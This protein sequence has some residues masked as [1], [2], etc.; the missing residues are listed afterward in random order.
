MLKRIVTVLFVFLLILTPVAAFADSEEDASYKVEKKDGGTYITVWG[1]ETYKLYSDLS[2]KNIKV[3]SDFVQGEII[4]DE[5]LDEIDTSVAGR[6]A[7]G[8]KAE[9]EG[10]YAVVYSSKDNIE[11]SCTVREGVDKNVEGIF[12]NDVQIYEGKRIT[13]NFFKMAENESEYVTVTEYGSGEYEIGFV[14]LGDKITDVKAGG[15][16]I[17]PYAAEAY[18][19]DEMNERAKG[20]D[21]YPDTLL[22]FSLGKTVRTCIFSH[23]DFDAQY[24]K[25]L[26]AQTEILGEKF[27]FDVTLIKIESLVKDIS[28]PPDFVP[29]FT[30]TFDG[31]I[32]NQKFPQYIAVEFTDGTKKNIG[33]ND[34]ITLPNGKNYQVRAEY[35]CNYG[36]GEHQ[37][38]FPFVY[39]FDGLIYKEVSVKPDCL[40]VSNTLSEISDKSKSEVEFG[41]RI[42]SAGVEDYTKADGLKF[43]FSPV[44]NIIDGCRF[45][46]N[47]SSPFNGILL[48]LIAFSPVIL[49]ILIVLA[50]I[51]IIKAK[52]HK[53]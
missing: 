34:W 18:D 48:F 10:Y 28:L 5:F 27:D 45:Y 43:V 20:V 22:T 7:F 3:K 23:T 42:L 8:I 1:I 21:L 29:S 46:F 52:K 51:F 12:K 53:K 15:E 32:L 33:F 13:G 50:V 44:K 35:S 26:K 11:I 41:L 30:L 40:S 6:K 37:S 17:Y 24:N 19:A 39:T 49:L 2:E 31:C 4:A 38:E 36:E 25:P 16:L 47:F 14:F 9:K